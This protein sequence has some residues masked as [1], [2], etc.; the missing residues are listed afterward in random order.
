LSSSSVNSFAFV[1]M[2]KKS[3]LLRGSSGFANV[4]CRAGF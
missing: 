2:E 3:W 1:K 4:P